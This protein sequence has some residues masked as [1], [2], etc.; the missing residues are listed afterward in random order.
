MWH[1]HNGLCVTVLYEDDQNFHFASSFGWWFV[2]LLQDS[3]I[4]GWNLCGFCCFQHC[5]HIYC[6]E[7]WRWEGGSLEG[8]GGQTSLR[9]RLWKCFYLFICC[10]RGSGSVALN[11]LWVCRWLP[12]S[13]ADTVFSH[14]ICIVNILHLTSKSYKSQ[15]RK[16]LLCTFS[17][18]F[19]LL[20]YKNVTYIACNSVC[21]S[22]CDS[23]HML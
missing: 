4:G 7:V 19:F 23:W 21:H 15:Y 17:V 22:T 1:Q 16:S 8:G 13:T 10:L 6:W 20:M 14:G 11:V 2:F 12:C 5:V 3:R 9:N 18:Y